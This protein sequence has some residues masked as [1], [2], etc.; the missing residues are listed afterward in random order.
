MILKA[1][2]I[3]N[4]KG[5]REPVRIEFAPLTLLFGPNSSGKSTILQALQF[6]AA[7]LKAKGRDPFDVSAAEGVD[8]GSFQD[9]VNGQDVSKAIKL[10]FE[11]GIP[12][13]FADY[14]PEGVF[15]NLDAGWESL[16]ELEGITES[17]GACFQTATIHLHV[18]FDSERGAAY[19]AEYRVDLDDIPFGVIRYECGNE[20]AEITFLNY[21]HPLLV[22]LDPQYGSFDAW[23]NDCGASEQEDLSEFWGADSNTALERYIEKHNKPPFSNRAFPIRICN[24]VG[25]LGSVFSPFNLHLNGAEDGRRDASAPHLAACCILSDGLLGPAWVLSVFLSVGIF[26]GPLRHIPTRDQAEITGG[27]EPNHSTG[28]AAWR[29]II[30]ASPDF[31]SELNSWLSDPD[32][33]DTRYGIQVF[34][35]R[36]IP[37]VEPLTE[38]LD[39]MT[40][41]GQ[42][43]AQL[44]VNDLPIRKRVVLKDL[45]EG[46]DLTL[47]DVGVGL[48][49]LLPILVESLR[50]QDTVLPGGALMAIEQ[51]ELHLHPGLQVRLADLFISTAMEVRRQFIIET[52]SEH[53]MLR[54][55]RRVRET[56]DVELESGLP[57]VKPYDVAVHFVE[58]SERGPVIHRIRIDEDGEFMDPW[59]RG[60]FPERM[61]EVYGDD[62]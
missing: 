5:I 12:A 60:F 15:K 56:N 25:A 57:P 28:E 24:Q 40:A 52:H 42:T 32:K 46:V 23:L 61:R 41:S 31:V 6:T 59:P 10:V 30:H 37:V 17:I 4:F 9:V 44:R 29:H 47:R 3:E 18:K 19:L 21:C 54:C 33:L 55:L 36:E 48:S 20:S 51:P 53:L 14:D 16:D 26:L 50:D 34:R 49:Q 45:H 62:L 22:E 38:P 58:P 39:S 1:L 7:L 27:Q 8:I 11:I 35:Y 13:V 2:T 43:L